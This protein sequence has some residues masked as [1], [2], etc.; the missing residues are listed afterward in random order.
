MEFLVDEKEYLVGVNPKNGL[1]VYFYGT[2]ENVNRFIFERNIQTV[3]R[4]SKE[5][6]KQI[7]M[8]VD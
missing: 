5:K 8:C 1:D 2:T 7:G 3:C 6:C 4:T